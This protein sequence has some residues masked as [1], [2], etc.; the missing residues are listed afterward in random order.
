MMTSKKLVA[1]LLMAT[2]SV[3]I[4]YSQTLTRLQVLSTSDHDKAESVSD[5]INKLGLGPA[6]VKNVGNLYKVQ[7]KIYSSLAEANFVKP[8]LLAAGYGDAFCVKDESDRKTISTPE[9]A[10]SVISSKDF[11][12]LEREIISETIKRE[13]PKIT[14]AQEKLNNREIS[15]NELFAKAMGYWKKSH[16]QSAI[17][18]FETY[19]SRFPQSYRASKANLM[20]GYWHLTAGN[21]EAA[22]SKFVSIKRDNVGRVE[23]GEA[24]LRLAYMA[25]NAKHEPEA[26]SLFRA[27]VYG[28]V[29][30]S[31]EN[32]AE[33]LLRLAALYHRGKDHE[34][35]EALYTKISQ[36][37]SDVNVKAYAEMQIAGLTLEQAWNG[38][39][40]FEEARSK[41]DTL[42]LAYPTAE[43]SIR[44]T[45]ALMSLETLCYEKK[46]GQAVER[47]ETLLNEFI[48]AKEEPLIK[49]WI[50]K[51]KLEIGKTDEAITLLDSIASEDS[52]TSVTGERFK[53]LDLTAEIDLLKASIQARREV[54]LIK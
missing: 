38:K 54:N 2:T 6:S 18:A 31:N 46:Y 40:K 23:E 52:R 41:C 49:Y 39:K 22:K 3:G 4:S 37:S 21:Q 32:R 8:K 1:I 19:V 36:T 10:L 17:S 20:V 24:T 53:G 33:A 9:G 25:L 51:A 34:A 50:A 35:S 42:L 5:H 28:E 7:T 26:L 14:D 16:V 47:K 15:E 29:T 30:S 13:Y 11:T 43:K 27:I 48:G 45:C 44:A 12:Q